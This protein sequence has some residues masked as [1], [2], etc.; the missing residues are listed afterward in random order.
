MRKGLLGGGATV[1]GDLQA[2][3]FAEVREF[4]AL[5]VA[6]GEGLLFFLFAVFVG[7]D[8]VEVLEEGWTGFGRAGECEGA[9]FDDLEAGGVEVCFA[10][11]VEVAE[12]FD[13]AGGVGAEMEL[14]GEV[15]LGAVAM[16]RGRRERTPRSMWSCCWTSASVESRR[17][18]WMY[19]SWSGR[20]WANSGS[21]WNGL[22]RWRTDL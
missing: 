3:L 2:G 6:E 19:S 17:R 1:R 11:G 7:E 4:E 22:A 5:G 13:G 10:A 14:V 18:S 16:E 8:A 9:L 15:E 12:L 20:R 21:G